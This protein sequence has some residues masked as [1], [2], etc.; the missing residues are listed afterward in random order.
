MHGRER[1]IASNWLAY[2]VGFLLLAALVAG[3]IAVMR[4]PKGALPKVAIG[5]K[6][7]V[8]YSH[9]A[10]A[11]DAAVLGQA[12]QNTGFF[13]DRGTSVLLSKSR[14]GTVVS[15]VLKDG[16]WDRPD[17]EAN[18]EEIGRRIA[19]SI[20]G[21]PIQVHLVDP[22]WAVRKSLEV[23]KTI[24]G[25]RDAIYYFGSATEGDAEA[26]GKALREAGYL[27][28]LG[29]SVVV[30]KDS[31]AAIGF[32]VGDG[33][34]ERPEAVAGFESLARRVAPSIGGLPIQVRLLNAEME[35]KKA[36]AVQ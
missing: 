2:G 5:T 21:F 28:D 18:F 25:A 31:G 15:F 7:A 35:V 29:V 1:S 8:Y 20:G 11:Q 22:S 6:D 36:V 30:S 16:A 27:E 23:G 24:I 19:T 4:R 33:V 17:A 32:V 9:A 26:L 34:W 3:G 14:A 13:G 10:T 12:L